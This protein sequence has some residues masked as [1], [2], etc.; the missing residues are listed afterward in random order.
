MSGC[1]S[2]Y[3][4]GNVAYSLP[5]NGGYCNCHCHNSWDGIYPSP[6][7]CHC[8]NPLAKPSNSAF[9][10]TIIHIEN[11]KMEEKIKSLEERLSILELRQL[12]H[13]K[14]PHKCPVCDFSGAIQLESME[15][16]IRFKGEIMNTDDGKSFISC[17]SCEG[18]G[19]VWG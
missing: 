16:V 8:N 4:I 19:I 10:P 7:F 13:S 5:S 2:P 3:T 15:E 11:K 1:H 12:D 6:C 17:R 9:I 14:K 18:K